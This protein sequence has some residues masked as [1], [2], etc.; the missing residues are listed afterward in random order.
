MMTEA[1]PNPNHNPTNTTNSDFKSGFLLSRAFLIAHHRR[2]EE[3]KKTV[4]N[5][6]KYCGSNKLIFKY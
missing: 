1:T 4:T 2:N 6:R 3:D 5:K